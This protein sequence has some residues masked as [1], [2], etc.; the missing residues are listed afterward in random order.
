MNE[1]IITVRLI[2]SL[3]I[4][5][6]CPCQKAADGLLCQTLHV[7]LDGKNILEGPSVI[8]CGD[9]WESE[10]RRHVHSFDSNVLRSASWTVCLLVLHLTLRFENQTWIRDSVTPIFVAS[11][12]LS[13]AEGYRLTANAASSS[14]ICW[15]LYL[16]RSLLWVWRG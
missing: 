7:W 11:W 2:L 16:M 6:S 15:L 14:R 1:E 5:Q 13:V 10:C 8:I 12:S 3:S 4:S 9:I